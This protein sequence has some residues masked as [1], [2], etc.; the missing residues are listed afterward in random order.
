MSKLKQ[1]QRELQ[2]IDSAKFQKLGD[3]YLAEKYSYSEII[4]VG[5]VIGKDKTRTGTPD[6]LFKLENGRFVFVEYTTQE[7]GI[8]KKFAEDLEKCFDEEKTNVSIPE[9][10]KIVLACNGEL[11]RNE[12]LELIKKCQEKGCNLEFIDL[13]TL[14]FELNQKYPQLAKDFLGV[15]CETFQILKPSAFV[16]EYQ[17]NQFSTPLTINSISVKKNWKKSINH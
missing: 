4:P 16:K 6:T 2:S 5:S 8:A 7:T 13:G 3:S 17:K 10:E 14:P 9:I 12:K 11:S 1:I 15:E